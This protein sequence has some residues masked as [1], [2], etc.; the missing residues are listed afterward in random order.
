MRATGEKSR[1][2]LADSA[3]RK[4]NFQ[5]AIA[6]QKEEVKE[7]SRLGKDA[8]DAK[9]LLSLYAYGAGAYDMALRV[10]QELREANPDDAETVENLGVILRL[11]RRNEEAAEALLEAHRL[12]PENPNICDALA[13]TYASLGDPQQVQKYGRLSLELKDSVAA[14]AVP[15]AKIPEEP[16]RPFSHEDKNIISFSLWGDGSQ[17]LG[18]ALRNAALAADL[19]PGWT[20]RFYCDDSVPSPTV[21]KLQAFGAEIV[22]RPAPDTFFDGLLWRFEVAGDPKVARFLIRDC[23]A[24]IN[25]RERVAVDAWLESDKYFHTMR[26]YASHTEVILA[27][28]WGG[29]GGVLPSIGEICE[30]FRSNTA[31]TR[32]YDQIVLRNCVWPVVRQSVLAHDSVYTGC[33][34]SV[35]FPE[36]GQLPSGQHVGQNEAAVRP[37]LQRDLHETTTNPPQDLFVLTGIDDDAVSHMED[38]LG[39][40]RGV[41]F[42]TGIGLTELREESRKFTGV[43]DSH[44]D[45]SLEDDIL[46]SSLKSILKRPDYCGVAHVG[47]REREADIEFLER[48]EPMIG[49]KILCLIRDPRD[50][51]SARRLT[52]VEA[53]WEL[54]R[55]WVA[56]LKQIARTNYRIPG[57]IEIVRY[58]DLATEK[59]N[60]TLKRVGR[61]LGLGRIA[62]AD[63]IP[64]EIDS[65]KPLPEELA[66]VIES[67]A[68]EMMAKLQ[69]LVTSSC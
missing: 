19:Y 7:C 5:C 64:R 40:V 16:P 26:D 9:K 30:N 35:P 51:A 48:I 60:A 34:G 25:V 4:G 27:G 53:A 33:L 20:C 10:L 63:T 56:H 22:S 50:T 37:E 59:A 11:L 38:L 29:V 39:K 15:L 44:E 36:T 68:G 47:V 57:S 1:R 67:T 49:C 6:L 8:S 12:A 17:Y 41:R 23:D 24:V 61:F 62:I 52:E 3:Y 46:V 21:R 32:T 66:E 58:E 55:T 13:H 18:G 45:T 43:L 69:Y 42:T 54:A 14:S 65:G 28:M 31:P 2:E